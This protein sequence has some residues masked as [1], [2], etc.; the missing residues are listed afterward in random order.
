MLKQ[1]TD[2]HIVYT[3]SRAGLE[4]GPGNG[5]YLVTKHAL[6]GFSETLYHELKMARSQI[7]VSVLCPG[8]VRTQI[9]DAHRNRP[10]DL[11]NPDEGSNQPQQGNIINQ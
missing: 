10:A 9:C 6:V 1:Q 7:G 2:C 4:T 8:F 3:A 11:L 5:I